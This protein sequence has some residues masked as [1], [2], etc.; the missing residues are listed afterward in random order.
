LADAAAE[1]VERRLPAEALPL[2]AD[3]LARSLQGMEDAIGVGQLIRRDAA[4]RARAAAADRME[5]VAFDLPDLERLRIDVRGDS[6]RRSRRRPRPHP[7]ALAAGV[8]PRRWRPTRTPLSTRRDGSS[9][10]PARCDAC[11]SARSC[12]R[13]R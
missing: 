4:F 13:T 6:A 10:P 5:R 2:A 11:G 9:P 7:G 1:V 12:S 8:R 3:A